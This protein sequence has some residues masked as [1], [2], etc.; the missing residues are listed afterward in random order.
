MSTEEKVIRGAAEIG[1]LYAL[2]IDLHRGEEL[3][4]SIS[5]LR[6]GMEKDLIGGS[7]KPEVKSAMGEML[8]F[9]YRVNR[10]AK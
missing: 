6:A 1:A 10:E 8:D 2:I 7:L 3:E 4:N 9:V 5:R